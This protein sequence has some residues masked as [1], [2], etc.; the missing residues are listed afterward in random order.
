MLLS[1][2]VP[3]YEFLSLTVPKIQRVPKISK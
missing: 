1:V 2:Y 3:E